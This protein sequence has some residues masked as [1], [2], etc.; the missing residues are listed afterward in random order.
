M[1]EP[2]LYT[3]IPDFLDALQRMVLTGKKVNVSKAAPGLRTICETDDESI[4]VLLSTV[5]E[6]YRREPF[7]PYEAAMKRWYD[8]LLEVFRLVKTQLAVGELVETKNK[9]IVTLVNG[10]TMIVKTHHGRITGVGDENVAILHDVGCEG[11]GGE[12]RT[13]VSEVKRTKFHT[14]WRIV[15]APRRTCWE[16]LMDDEYVC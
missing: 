10:R 3:S 8:A 6:Y 13:I 12:P 14:F 1:R 11:C 5:R 4:A 7:E 16:R 15:E 2:T 9:G